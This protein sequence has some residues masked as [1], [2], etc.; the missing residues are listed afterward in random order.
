MKGILLKEERPNYTNVLFQDAQDPWEDFHS[1]LPS[2]ESQSLPTQ[3]A[4]QSAKATTEKDELDED[5]LIYQEV[6]KAKKQYEKKTG[7]ISL[8]R[9]PSTP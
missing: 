8:S 6:H 9:Y 5:Y 1:L 4:S 2:Q 7:D 3:I